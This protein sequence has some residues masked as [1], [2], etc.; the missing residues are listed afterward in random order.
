MAYTADETAL[1]AQKPRMGA[2]SV[3]EKIEQANLLKTQG[4][5]LFKGGEYKKAIHKYSAVFLYVNGLSVAGDGMS[6]YSQ[7]NAA[8]SATAAEGDE[9]KQLKIVAYT[10]TAMSH[11]KLEAF[12]KAL[13]VCE[14]VLAI[15]PEHVKALFRQGQAYAGKGKY[16]MAKEIL[17][18]A[19][20][21]EPKNAAVRNELKRVI[22]ESKLH[23]EEDDLKNKFSNM[24]NKSGGIYK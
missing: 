4:N 15:E 21:L 20:A 12:D 7:G 3:A 5:T 16:S 22:D 14:K 2:L 10:N 1:L 6:T 9:I 18:K 11:L 13:D 24:F 8:M 19:L 17:K 23:P